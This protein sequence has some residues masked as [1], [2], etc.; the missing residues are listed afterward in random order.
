MDQV[1]CTFGYDSSAVGFFYA[2]NQACR[3]ARNKTRC[4]AALRKVK[5]GIRR[6]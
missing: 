1:F 5:G 2:N 3:A 6:T 4:T